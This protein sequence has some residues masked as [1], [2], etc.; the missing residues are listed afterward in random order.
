MKTIKEKAQ[1]YSKICKFCE[2]QNF[3]PRCTSCEFRGKYQGFLAGA[4]EQKDI[5]IELIP[6]I[7]MRWLMIEGKR[8]LWVEYAN[9]AMEDWQ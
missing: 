1:E 5:D 8:P 9:K 7:Y 6:Q 2:E 4:T 3:S